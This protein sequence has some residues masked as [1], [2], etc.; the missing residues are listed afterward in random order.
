[1]CWD[2]SCSNFLNCSLNKTGGLQFGKDDIWTSYHSPR[3]EG[4][5][6]PGFEEEAWGKCSQLAFWMSRL[7]LF[8]CSCYLTSAL[9]TWLLLLFPCN[10]GT[11]LERARYTI[12]GMLFLLLLLLFA[13]LVPKNF[14]KERRKTETAFSPSLQYIDAAVHR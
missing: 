7:T 8:A 5:P 12:E 13:C 4:V 6:A 9:A 10:T 14:S 3:N 1:M 11:E 2:Y